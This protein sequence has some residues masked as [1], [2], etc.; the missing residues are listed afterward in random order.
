MYKTN[1]VLYFSP[2]VQAQKNGQMP[3][4]FIL[5]INHV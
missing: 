3:V 2:E 5:G 1:K 4:F